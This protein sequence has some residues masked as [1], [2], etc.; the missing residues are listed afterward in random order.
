MPKRLELDPLAWLAYTRVSLGEKQALSP[1]A[2]R[3]AI[4]EA[5]ARAGARVVATFDDD[6]TSDTPAEQRP[7]L[8]A[9]LASVRTLRAGVVCVARRDRLSREPAVSL[10][11]ERRLAAWGA[12]LVSADGAGNGTDPAAAFTRLLLDGAAQFERAMIRA[13]TRDAMA[14]LKRAGRSTGR[15][16]WGWQAAP[17]GALAPCPAERA[18]TERARELVARGA[19][20]REACAI[21]TDE[22]HRTRRLETRRG[23][24]GGA[25]IDASTLRRVVLPARW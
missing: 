7:A 14:S 4:G 8:A 13:R 17:D 12:R 24:I 23:P 25:P 21:L 18:A 1:D 11:V 15:P 3:Y 10:D 16:P 6:V 19:S 2:Q 9:A 22:G 20:L 5:A